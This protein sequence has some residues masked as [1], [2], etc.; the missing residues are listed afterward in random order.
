MKRF[1]LLSLALLS[2]A[3]G[4]YAAD[5]KETLTSPSGNI[6]LEVTVG[7]R[8]TLSA[9]RGSEQILKDCP[10]SLQIAGDAFGTNPKLSGTKRTSVNETIRP[11]V[12]LKYA[13]VP[14]RANQLS[15][16]FRS[17][18]GLDLRAY[19]NGVAYRFTLNKGKGQ[20][21]VV[22]EGLELN[23]PEDGMAH[24]SQTRGFGTSYE[25]PYTHVATSEL[26]AD[27]SSRLTSR[28]KLY[29]PTQKMY[30]RMT[31]RRTR[32]STCLA[33]EENVLSLLRQT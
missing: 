26:K 7:E 16:S 15:L 13:A 27:G 25:N 29:P 19:D 24:I 12:P 10:L 11:T 4:S 8:L 20:V 1:L 28:Q 33:L 3:C 30:N 18:I 23:L 17:G 5:K 6:R 21:D 9:F 31:K 2:L 32:I 22:S 14:N